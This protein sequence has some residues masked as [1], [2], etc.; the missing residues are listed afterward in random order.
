MASG[1]ISIPDEN[2]GLSAKKHVCLRYAEY[3]DWHIKK[4]FQIV[5]LLKGLLEMY[6]PGI[7]LPA[8]LQCL[9]SSDLA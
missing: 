4:R 6:H 5:E 2:G 7:S 9:L 3:Y 1:R 8:S